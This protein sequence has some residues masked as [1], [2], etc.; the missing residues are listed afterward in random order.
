MKRIAVL[1][2]IH[3]NA[4]LLK[5]VICDLEKSNIDEYIFC[6]DYVTDGFENDEVINIIKNLSNNVIAGNR[7]TT[8]RNYD[9]KSWENS[10][11]WYPSLYAYHSISEDNL[12]Y[13]K[14]LEYEKEIIIDGKKIYFTHI[15]PYNK[16]DV[17]DEN[18]VVL[19]DKMINDYDSDIFIFG[20]T[21]VPFCVE[22]KGKLFMN[23]GA[24]SYTKNEPVSSC[25]IITIDGDIK[26]QHKKYTRNI[27]VIKNYYL[28]SNYYNVCPEWTNI[29]LHSYMNGF[30]HC[31]HFV[32]YL[33]STGEKDFDLVWENK[34][35]EYMNVNNLDIFVK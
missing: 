7:E 9:G 24:L 27:D 31:S 20:H 10:I 18:S 4:T 33:F 8:I 21:H 22:Y 28:E 6:G 3:S 11:Q 30:D 19:F 13:I 16:K 26:V 32:D 1:S 14:S 12:E 17:I 34:F 35:T 25:M 2:D 23:P 5:E 15:S 29:I